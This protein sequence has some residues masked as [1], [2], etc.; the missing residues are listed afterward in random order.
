MESDA[1]PRINRVIVTGFLQQQPE[2]RHTPTG[3]PVSSFRIRA[4][5]MIRDRRG[6]ARETV[7]TFTVVV[8]QDLAVRVCEEIKNGQGVYVEGSLHSRSFLTSGGERRTVVEVYA[9]MLETV[10]IFLNPRD[11]HAGGREEGREERPGSRDEHSAPEEAYEHPTGD[12]H[13]EG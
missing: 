9:D 3:V 8:W 12:H 6:L 11:L 1:L 10:P 7:S 13:E 4:G 5:R 2:L